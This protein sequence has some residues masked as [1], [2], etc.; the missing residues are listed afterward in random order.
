MY[1]FNIVNGII[2]NEASFPPRKKN[3]V[4][5]NDFAFTMHQYCRYSKFTLHERYVFCKTEHPLNELYNL[6]I[7]MGGTFPLNSWD[8][9]PANV[10]IMKDCLR[11]LVDMNK[12]AS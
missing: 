6:Y 7:M 10:V 1:L 11:I 8:P 3:K 5:F 9:I 2:I 4:D 12:N